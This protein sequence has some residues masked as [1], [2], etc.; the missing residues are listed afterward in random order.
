M[1]S[2]ASCGVPNGTILFWRDLTHTAIST[3]PS[4]AQAYM[5]PVS[6]IMNPCRFLDCCGSSIGTESGRAEISQPVGSI[7]Q[8]SRC[9]RK[10]R[11]EKYLMFCKSVWSSCGT[12]CVWM[13]REPERKFA[14]TVLMVLL[15]DTVTAPPKCSTS[16]HQ[17]QR[18]TL[19]H[20]QAPNF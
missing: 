7:G 10:G 3:S 12:L 5:R 19:H 6:A 13:N 8:E 4:I 1:I 15:S 9:F 20:Q 17:Y 14:K 16:I 11:K 2:I 18:R